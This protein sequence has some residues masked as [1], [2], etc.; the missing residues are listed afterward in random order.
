M[1]NT[2]K[3]F[4]VNHEYNTFS[5]FF[6]VDIYF[7]PRDLHSTSVQQDLSLPSMGRGHRMVPCVILDALHSHILYVQNINNRG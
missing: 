2:T 7:S 3:H 4:F 1:H 5:I 6:P